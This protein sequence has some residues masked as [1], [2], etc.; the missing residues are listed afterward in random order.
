MKGNAAPLGMGSYS[1]EYPCKV[2]RLDAEGRPLTGTNDSYVLKLGPR[3]K[4]PKELCW[5]LTTYSVPDRFLVA[6][7]SHG[8]S[9]VERGDG[10]KPDAKVGTCAATGSI[11]FT[12]DFC[13]DGK[14]TE[15]RHLPLALGYVGAWSM[16][17]KSAD[18]KVLGTYG[19]YFRSHRRPTQ[20]ERKGVETLA[21]TAALVLAA[22]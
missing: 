2:F 20:E 9:T 6:N 14:W 7:L 4:P 12:P 18:G 22:N 15:L 8:H 10:L 3:Q 17:I 11:V 5:S 19:T 1:K 13:A 21:A 16:P